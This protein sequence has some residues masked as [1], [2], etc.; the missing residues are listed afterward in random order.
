[1][2]VE[3]LLVVYPGTAKQDESRVL[4]PYLVVVFAARFHC[5]CWKRA[6]AAA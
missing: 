5:L 6:L 1:M 4:L 2:Q 3:G